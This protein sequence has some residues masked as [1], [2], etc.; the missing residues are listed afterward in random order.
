MESVSGKTFPAFVK[1]KIFNPLGMTNSIAYVAGLSCVPNRAY[2]YVNGTSGWEFSDQS[3]T[4]AV[5]GD[6][7]IYCSVADLFKWDLALY[8]E[9]LI[10]LKMLADA[11]TAHSSQSDFKGS[12]YGYGWYV[13]N[14]RDTEH[15]WHYGSTCG[16]ST[17]VERFPGRRLSVIVLTNRRNAEI[18]PIV[19]KL[20]ELF[21]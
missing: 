10:S 9:K 19:E 1:E 14:F 8:T 13:G 6:G 21:W 15:I 12:G 7:G 3:V 2:G 20:V 18:S 4:S 17:R 5:L 16:F 11:F